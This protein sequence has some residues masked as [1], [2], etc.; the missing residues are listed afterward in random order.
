MRRPRESTDKQASLTDFP[1]DIMKTRSFPPAWL[2]G[3]VAML[4]V[5][6]LSSCGKGTGPA[7]P[8]SVVAEKKD[9]PAKADVA[10]SDPVKVELDAAQSELAMKI[11]KQMALAYKNAKS[12]SDKG[13]IQKR[14]TEGNELYDKPIH[15]FSVSFVRPN[16][17]RL[18]CYEG[19]M[20]S[21][22]KQ[23]AAVIQGLDD[24]VVV[25]KAPE[26]LNYHEVHRGGDTIWMEVMTQ[27]IA[28]GNP[29][30][31]L[32]MADDALQGFLGG[33]ESPILDKGE[34]ID[35]HP[36]HRIKIVRPDGDLV[37]SIDEKTSVLRRIELPMTELKKHLDPEG[38]KK[39]LKITSEFTDAQLDAEIPDAT[40]AIQLPE[41]AFHV[42]HFVGMARPKLPPMLGKAIPNL[43]LVGL[44]GKEF[45]LESLKGKLVVLDFWGVNCPPCLESLPL[46]NTV[47]QKYKDNDQVRILAV[48]IDL[49]DQPNAELTGLFKKLGVEIP[50]ARI[51]QIEDLEKIGIEEIPVMMI[52]DAE[53]R[54]QEIKLGKDD[55]LARTLPEKIDQIRAGKN[56]FQEVMAAYKA[57]LAEYEQTLRDAG[58][59]AGAGADGSVAVA[60][61]TEPARLKLAKMWTAEDVKA[62]GNVTFLPAAGD[63]PAKL[64]VFDGWKSVIEVDLA[65]KVLGRHELPLAEDEPSC[66]LRTAVDGKGKRYFA[67]FAA[68]LQRLHLFDED[69]KLVW[70]HPDGKHDGLSEVRLVDL[71]GKGDLT[72]VVGYFGQVGVHGV[73]LK[74]ERLW[75]N[76]MLEHVGSLAVGKPG[77]VVC[78]N[79]QGS[80]VALDSKGKS[81]GEFQIGQSPSRPQG[82]LMRHI[83]A[84]DL[85]SDGQP[86]YAGLAFNAAQ[87]DIAVGISSE[88]AEIWSQR[89]PVGRHQTPVEPI[90]AGR[91]PGMKQDCWILAG[92]N[93]AIL[94]VAA[95]GTLIDEF[96]Y[97]AHLSGVALVKDGDKTLLVVAGSKDAEHSDLTAWQVT[98]DVTLPAATPEKGPSLLEESTD[99]DTKK[100]VEK[101]ASKPS[102][103][104]PTSDKPAPRNEEKPDEGQ[105]EE[106]KAEENKPEEKKPAGKPAPKKTAEKPAEEEGPRLE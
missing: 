45:T 38:T 35:G 105:P 17:I 7:A 72:V 20:T 75:A 18:Q 97:G 82:R 10:T 39:G 29:Q 37:L 3:L 44:D 92:A 4:S 34:K 74:G 16:K 31:A 25:D 84:A 94:F 30:L 70:H 71:E 33:G 65:G 61:R 57:Q 100:P 23:L 77:S 98:G 2:L 96:H 19:V 28:G 104:K 103:D 99:G 6:G 67:T 58:E 62:P 87:N 52:V 86:E 47:Y 46:L 51:K 15:D 73:S 85:N 54:V 81:T 106:K 8:P 12:Y 49:A 36:C 55:R 40:F 88:G 80:L 64:L 26:K 89:L 91:L 56:L 11:L 14:Y 93:G 69:W 101:T 60:A 5:A 78:T 1:E 59:E 32:L 90:V 50:I 79:A 24:Q 43:T 9:G 63:K 41:G 76:R 83:A 48:N 27:Q 22:G 95:D 68:G 102:V 53:Q 42:R 66:Y 13:H 21:D